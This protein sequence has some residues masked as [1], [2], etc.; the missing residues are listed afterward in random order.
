MDSTS[1]SI[2]WWRPL[3]AAALGGVLAIACDQG[4]DPKV[5]R[6]DLRVEELEARCDYLVRCHF[7]PDEA[8]CMASETFDAGLVQAVGGTSFDRVSYD[9][10]QAAAW[11]STLRTISCDATV[12]NARILADA[13]AA[14]FSGRVEAGGACF[15][16]EECR[17]DAICD[18]S[19]CQGGQL[20]C[21]GECVEWRVLSVGE[22]CPLSQPDTRISARCEDLAY[23][24]P[25]P[26]DGSGMPAAQGQCVARADN[27]LP[28]D[29]VNG[30]LDGQR[31]NVGGSGNCYKLSGSGEDCNPDLQQG[32]CV[33]VNEVCSPASST[34]VPAPGPGEACV[35]GECAPWAVCMDGMTCVARPRAGEACDGNDLGGATC[36]S[37]GFEGGALAC[38]PDCTDLDPSGCISTFC[39]NGVRDA[40][41][42]C[43]GSDLGGVTCERL[44]GEAGQLVCTP[45][46]Q[47]FDLLGCGDA[48]ADSDLGTAVGPAV[49]MGNTVGEDDDLLL[50]C[51]G[52]G[53][54][55]HV[56]SFVA[57]TPGLH[58]FD[59]F[60][61]SYDT[62]LA[63]FASCHP[64][65]QLV[66]NDDFDDTLVSQVSLAL[67]A[68]Q[69][70]F[71]V[72]DGFSGD[73][74]DW[75][76]SITAPTIPALPACAEEDLL[77]ATGSPVTAG[78]TIGEDDDLEQGCNP[79]P[80]VD[81]VLRFIAPWS[82]SFRFDTSGSNFDTVLSIHGS[83][84]PG[85]ELDCNDDF[86][87]LTSQIIV[88]L[89]AGQ[90][91][92]V[93]VGGYDGDA[94]QWVLSI[95]PT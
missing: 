93:M 14:V 45:D 12:E 85:A 71:V 10:E 56:M 29:A 35:L 63:I 74:G 39:G 47:G 53:G 2:S 42:Q 61:S 70:V 38:R 64:S 22:T 60:G 79:G 17:G 50:G 75:V 18:R 15:A 30:C 88:D 94:G 49:A 77:W 51:A 9:P 20:C 91:I 36:T 16:D 73:V 23:C 31:C 87:G 68:G 46:C 33:A 19:L 41:E 26:D 57:A 3:A 67:D 66:C 55:D 1:R 76:L 7:M 83:C 44:V 27:G 11:L 80:S 32:S 92:L 43:D 84:S 54:S 69:R 81:H 5:D 86:D 8:T 28:C 52:D 65:S 58:V 89:E 13:R 62:A 4:D 25:P 40:G 6:S 90:S 37:L 24:Q 48:C 82:G 95:E 72:V 78:N 34:C 59:T 21:T